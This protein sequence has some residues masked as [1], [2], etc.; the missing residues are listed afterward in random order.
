M[1]E[2]FL[3]ENPIVETTVSLASPHTQEVTQVVEKATKN[4]Q[5]REREDP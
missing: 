4:K 3:K 5:K 2:G 1:Y